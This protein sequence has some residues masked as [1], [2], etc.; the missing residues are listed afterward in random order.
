[1]APGI[2]VVST[3]LAGSYIRLDGT[4]VAAPFVSGAAALLLQK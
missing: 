3:G 2:N 1:M 4:S